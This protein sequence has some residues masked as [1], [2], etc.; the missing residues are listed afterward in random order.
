VRGTFEVDPTDRFGTGTLVYNASRRGWVV[1]V[2]GRFCRN[3]SGL[4]RVTLNG[5]DLTF[6]HISD[7]C[8]LRIAVLEGNTFA[9]LTSPTQIQG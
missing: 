1:K 3:T 8:Q 7:P 6:G 9:P 4:Y 5:A 2:L